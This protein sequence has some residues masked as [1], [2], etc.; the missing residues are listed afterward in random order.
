[1]TLPFLTLD[2]RMWHHRSAAH[3][4]VPVNATAIAKISSDGANLVYLRRHHLLAPA[5]EPPHR[6]RPRR[7]KHTSQP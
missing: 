1:M 3:G 2:R 4:G 6:H 5:G 7:L